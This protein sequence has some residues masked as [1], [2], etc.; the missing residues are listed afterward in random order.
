MKKLIYTAVLLSI[1]TITHSQQ[2]TRFRGPNGSGISTAKN[3]PVQ[4]ETG[5]HRWKAE[6]QGEGH[7]S[8]VVWGNQLF[9]TSAD[10]TSGRRYLS[11]LNTEDGSQNWKLEFPFKK[12][13]KHGQNSYA[14]NSPTVDADHVYVLWQSKAACTLFAIKHDSE[15]A[16]EYD[17]GPNNNGQGGATS[18]IVHGDYVYVSNDQKGNSF[19]VAVNRENGQEKWKIPRQG[20]RACYSTPCVFQSETD[21][22]EIVFTHCFEGIVGVDPVSGKQNWMIDVFG[23]FSQRAVG[24]PF[25]VGNVIIGTSGARG[26]ERN[27][28]AVRPGTSNDSTSEAFRVTKSA[29]HVPTPLAYEKWLFL[30]S[31]SG[32]VSCVELASNKVVWQKRVGGNYFSSPICIDG[33][34]YNVDLEGKVIVVNA[35]DKFE[36]LGS[37]ELEEPSRSTPA[38]SNGMLFVRT[39]SSVFAIGN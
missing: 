22:E 19:L 20:K 26:G 11:A 25:Q 8:P 36:L 12:Y 27:V 13:K 31:D 38:V 34:L 37:S 7:S 5:K 16:W 4:W 18:P 32:I 29:P 35:S 23:R 9:V 30:W 28:V 3:I 6:L 10:V 21:Y 24:S 2:W 15:I 14:S 33:K 1:C 17:L 39:Y